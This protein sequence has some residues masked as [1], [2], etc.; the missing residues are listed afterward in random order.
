M[1]LLRE[2]LVWFVVMAFSSL[3]ITILLFRIIKSSARIGSKDTRFAKK[4]ARKKASR[5]VT[6]FKSKEYLLTGGVAG[7]IFVFFASWYFFTPLLKGPL[8]PRKLNP[9]KSIEGFQTYSDSN[10]AI[11]IPTSYQAPM[12]HKVL[13]FRS[14]DDSLNFQ[15]HE[16]FLL[17]T[18]STFTE[19]GETQPKHLKLFTHII[20]D[21]KHRRLYLFGY[22]DSDQGRQMMST[23]NIDNDNED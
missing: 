16:G 14:T 6:W 9:L 17:H 5:Y 11:S 13:E 23:L 4:S 10:F 19:P 2:P 12:T 22:E 21:E 1:N 3:I 15:G 18:E 20:L 7:F 8:G